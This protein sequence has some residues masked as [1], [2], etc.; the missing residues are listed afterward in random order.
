MEYYSYRRKANRD[1]VLIIKNLSM[2]SWLI[3]I[4]VVISVVGFISWALAPGSIIYFALKPANILSGEAIWT[5]IVHMFAHGNLIHLLINMFVLFSL[6]KLSEKI[7]G[8]KR[9]LWFYL[10]AGVFAGILSVLLAGY[11][12]YGGGAKIFG[13][14]DTYMVGASGAIFGIAGLF[15]MLLPKIRFGII[16]IPFF[17][18]PAYVMVPLVLILTWAATLAAG[19][20]IGNVAHLGG[21][22]AGLGYGYYLRVR[23]RKKVIM[24]QR[25]FR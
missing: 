18:L 24:L 15:V 7:I 9:F 10:A 16:F 4:S 1:F 25:M 12:G 17:S 5:L 6:G 8:R 23:Y 13:T 22:L 14:P 20:P 21:F 3:I 2:V 19:L 11:F